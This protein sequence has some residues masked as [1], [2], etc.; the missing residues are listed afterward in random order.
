[1]IEI[2]FVFT[3][4]EAIKEL[5]RGYNMKV[6]KRKY[7]RTEHVHGSNE[8]EVECEGWFAKDP[9][10]GVFHPL[11]VVFAIAMRLQLK[12][13]MAESRNRAAFYCELKKIQ[14]DL[15]NF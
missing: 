5:E 13:L 11:K 14:I 4:E 3:E 2:P 12:T 8:Y 9:T 15:N 10:T 6:E 1:M 7:T